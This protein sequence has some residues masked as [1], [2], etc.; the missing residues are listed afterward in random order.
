MPKRITAAEARAA[1]AVLNVNKRLSEATRAENARIVDAFLSNLAVSGD[2]ALIKTPEQWLCSI[3]Q[4]NMTQDRQSFPT[5]GGAL[6]FRVNGPTEYEITLRSFD[7]PPPGLLEA[8]L[9]RD[10]GR[11]GSAY[12]N[13]APTVVALALP[14]Q[15]QVDSIDPGALRDR[16]ILSAPTRQYDEIDD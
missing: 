15:T 16:G 6:D 12:L 8:L 13:S 11:A 5:F 7:A 3:E 9:G 10:T 1:F 2:R 4:V 14:T